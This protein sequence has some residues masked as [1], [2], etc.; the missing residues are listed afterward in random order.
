MK[1]LRPIEKKIHCDG[2]LL[3][4]PKVAPLE[5]AG[6]KSA[7]VSTDLQNVVTAEVEIYLGEPSNCAWSALYLNTG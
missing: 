3:C 4:S 1:Y 6:E 5:H 7:Q 2:N